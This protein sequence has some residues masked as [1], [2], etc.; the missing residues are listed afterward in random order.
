MSKMKV[1]SRCGKHSES[2]YVFCGFC[3]EP[4]GEDMKLIVELDNY[5]AEQKGHRSGKMIRQQQWQEPPVYGRKVA[6]E[7]GS[8]FYY[9]APE[10]KSYTVPLLFL[11]IALI[12]ITAFI[13]L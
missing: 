13:L 2:E 3:G 6:E 5:F 12:V 4:L 8:R 7:E 10:E 9:E 11:G 1:C